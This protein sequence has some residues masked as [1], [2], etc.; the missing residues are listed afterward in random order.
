MKTKRDPWDHNGQSRHAR[1]YGREHERIRSE[2][3]RTVILCEECTRQGRTTVGT[4]ADHIIPL[5]KGGPTV[6]S[7]YQLLCKRCSNIKTIQDSGRKRRI[8]PQIGL[9]GWPIEEPGHAE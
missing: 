3:L 7:N 1:G 4:I 6:R 5:S 8:R 2:L 9:D